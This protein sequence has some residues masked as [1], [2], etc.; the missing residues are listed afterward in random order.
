MSV[1]VLVRYLTVN[2]PVKGH[3]SR[4]EDG[5]TKLVM[6]KVALV[7]EFMAV[8]ILIVSTELANEQEVMVI[9]IA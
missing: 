7:N 8:P 6:L 1:F 3:W 4:A 9:E 2:P 5:L